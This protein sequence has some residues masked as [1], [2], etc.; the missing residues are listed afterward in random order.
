V[1]LGVAKSLSQNVHDSSLTATG[2]SD[3][4]E[5]VTHKR[6]FV[7]LDNLCLPGCFFLEVVGN[8]QLFDFILLGFVGLV[9]N[10]GLSGEDILNQSTEEG[11]ILGNEL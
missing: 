8:Q 10:V 7:E 9:R 2:R 4:H 5:A 3:K 6:S 11:L 1:A